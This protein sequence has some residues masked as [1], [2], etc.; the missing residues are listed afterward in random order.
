M[1][2]SVGLV[3][4]SAVGKSIAYRGMVSG[5]RHD[6]ECC[7]CLLFSDVVEE[8]NRR[9]RLAESTVTRQAGRTEYIRMG[10]GS[11]RPSSILSILY[12]CHGFDSNHRYMGYLP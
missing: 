10:H 9:W 7:G 3:M 5:A 4:L 1:P 12:L 11:H 2:T 6:A 8:A